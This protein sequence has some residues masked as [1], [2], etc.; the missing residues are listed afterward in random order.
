MPYSVPVK[1]THYDGHHFRSLQEARFACFFN[2]LEIDYTYE[3]D[4][5]E[6]PLTET[7]PL[8]PTH[9]SNS[10]KYIPDFY[11]PTYDTFIEVKGKYPLPIEC[12]KA[13]ALSKQTNK[14][15]IIMWSLKH[16]I[17]SGYSIVFYPDG[18]LEMNISFTQCHL[19]DRIGLGKGQCIHCQ[20]PIQ[21]G[22][23]EDI[24]KALIFAQQ[25]EF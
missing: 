14:Q 25:K 8:L 2:E 22:I 20:T 13:W 17:T 1:Q 7:S 24:K 4:T 15:V 3:P 21:K 9:P 18:E 10:V 12:F 11:L 16:R 23:R 6:F 19:C 5:Y